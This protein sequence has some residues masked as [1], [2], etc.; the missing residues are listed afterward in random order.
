VELPPFSES[1]IPICVV[2]NGFKGKDSFIQARFS[3][4]NKLYAV[5][6][7]LNN[8]DIDGCTVCQLAN[9]SNEVIT[10]YKNTPIAV[11]SLHL[12]DKDCFSNI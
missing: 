11:V 12:N 7:S 2:N 9:A 4:I 5:A 1:F 3:G 6:R 10:V 8:I